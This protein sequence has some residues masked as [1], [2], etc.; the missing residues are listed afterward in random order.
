[1]VIGCSGRLDTA[2]NYWWPEVTTAFPAPRAKRVSLGGAG[3]D[4]ARQPAGMKEGQ[5][6]S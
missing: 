4:R 5:G 2:R 1:M 3:P 6:G